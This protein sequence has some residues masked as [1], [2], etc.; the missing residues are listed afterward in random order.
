MRNN[1]GS[2]KKAKT[3]KGKS[4]D[5]PPKFI[6]QTTTGEKRQSQKDKVMSPLTI[7]L[8]KRKTGMALGA[9]KS[10]LVQNLNRYTKNRLNFFIF[11]VCFE[12]HRMMRTGLFFF[13]RD[14]KIGLKNIEG[15]TLYLL[16]WLHYCSWTANFCPQ[17]VPRSIL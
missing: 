8:I 14:K 6:A 12:Y 11:A 15:Q 1:G 5:I 2:K 3:G 4:K 10:R 9:Y 13:P 7:L 17:F 16:F